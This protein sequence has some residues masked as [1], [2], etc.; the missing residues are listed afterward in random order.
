MSCLRLNQILFS[1]TQNLYSNYASAVKNPLT[2]R[3]GGEGTGIRRRNAAIRREP[4]E[5]LEDFIDNTI[6]IICDYNF[7]K[8]SG[9]SYV[10]RRIMSPN[11]PAIRAR[12]GDIYNDFGDE[13]E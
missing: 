6:P 4:L 11:I 5:S 9:D 13:L 12:I 1:Y 7:N 8:S 3:I 2:K 10:D